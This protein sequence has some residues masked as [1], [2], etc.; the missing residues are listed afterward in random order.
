MKHSL[1][2][3]ADYFTQLV[4]SGAD[5]LKLSITP[6]QIE[7]F[8]TYT[9][10][11]LNWNRKINLT[12]I[13]TTEDIAVKHFLDAMTALPFLPAT[14]NVLDIG[15]GAGFPGLVIKILNPALSVTL[16]DSV[17]KKVS[18]LQH[19][20]RTLSI[21]NI[22]ARHIR[23]EIFNKKPPE[24]KR[25]QAV[26][27]RALTS[28]T[29]FVNLAIPLIAPDGFI[30]AYKGKLDRQEVDELWAAYDPT[31]LDLVKKTVLLPHTDQTRTIVILQPL[32]R[33][34]TSCNYAASNSRCS[35]EN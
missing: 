17:R 11:L 2:F 32:Q 8:L 25:Y 18:F 33:E 14:G 31:S 19:T 23:A 1:P 5:A 20:I 26:V 30:Y 15:S 4:E 3:D 21:E 6:R 34:G 10:L 22:S 16:I 9:E 24:L 12:R 35:I 29:K 7:H 28:L 27:S 13:T